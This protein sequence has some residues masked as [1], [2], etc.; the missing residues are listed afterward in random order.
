MLPKNTPIAYGTTDTPVFIVDGVEYWT[1]T[2]C[3]D[4]LIAHGERS[5]NAYQLLASNARAGRVRFVNSGRFRVYHA[6]DVRA[7]AKTRGA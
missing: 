4:L 1:P 7:L 2:T 5:G 3:C 6:G